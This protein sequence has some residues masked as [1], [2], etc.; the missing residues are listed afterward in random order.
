MPYYGSGT[1]MIAQREIR[2]AA[3]DWLSIPRNADGIRTYV[4]RWTARMA[5]LSTIEGGRPFRDDP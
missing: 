2:D 5:A 1:E 4:D 3:W